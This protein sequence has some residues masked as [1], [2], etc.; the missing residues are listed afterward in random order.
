MPTLTLRVE[1]ELLAQLDDLAAQQ[2]VPRSVVVRSL[3][4]L[5]TAASI[6]EN[7]LQEA[8]FSYKQL[9]QETFSVAGNEIQARLQELLVNQL[10]SAQ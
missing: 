7:A 4:R 5:N 6:D 3:L 10:E 2:G 8:I 9:V 1:D